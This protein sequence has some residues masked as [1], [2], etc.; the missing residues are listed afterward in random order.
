MRNDEWERQQLPVFILEQTVDE[1]E[2]GLCDI[3][4]YC[5][6][7][8]QLGNTCLIQGFCPMTPFIGHTKPSI[9][10]PFS[11]GI[12]HPKGDIY[13]INTVRAVA[14]DSSVLVDHYP[15]RFSFG[16]STRLNFC[17]DM[18]S[19]VVLRK[20]NNHLFNDFRLSRLCVCSDFDLVVML[21]GFDPY[22]HNI[23][24]CDMH[25]SRGNTRL[26]LCS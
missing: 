15:M 26:M 4:F 16:H 13:M 22:F 10:H 14:N 6:A 9:Y 17:M 2:H 25:S 18:A 21:T 11:V 5:A 24:V 12:E 19:S 7:R 23:V 3:T 20:E 1:Q 8:S